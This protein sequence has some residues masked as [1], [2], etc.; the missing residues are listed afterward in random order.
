[1]MSEMSAKRINKVKSYNFIIFAQS[2]KKQ[3]FGLSLEN[4]SSFSAS[5]INRKLI[6]YMKLFSY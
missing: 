4:A 1:M 6:H 2:Y 5:L 3:K